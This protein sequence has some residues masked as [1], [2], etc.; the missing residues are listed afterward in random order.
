M[1]EVG[2]LLVWATV[3]FLHVNVGRYVKTHTQTDISVHVDNE[4]Q[5]LSN[6]RVTNRLDL[7]DT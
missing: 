1:H 2:V 5:Y 6:V 7:L 3:V 4:S